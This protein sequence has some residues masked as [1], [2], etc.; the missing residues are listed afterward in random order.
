MG[1]RVELAVLLLLSVFGS[2]FFAV[3]EIETPAVRKVIK[4]LTLTGAT[5]LLYLVA[6]HWSLVLPG[7]AALAGSVFH[8]RWCQKNGIDPLRATPRRRY[9]ELRGW[10]W[11]E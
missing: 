5:L 11:P 6:G 2:G 4:W 3:F 10:T 1:I 8:L 9:Y 7:S